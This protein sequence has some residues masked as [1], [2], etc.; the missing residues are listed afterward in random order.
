MWSTISPLCVWF[1][2]F[3]GANLFMNCFLKFHFFFL[4]LVVSHPRL[5]CTQCCLNLSFI[6]TKKFN[7]YLYLYPPYQIKT[8]P[9]ADKIL[10][11]FRT[12]IFSSESN[13]KNWLQNRSII[14]Y[15]I[16][17]NFF[18]NNPTSNL[19]QKNSKQKIM[20]VF[21][22]QFRYCRSCQACLR[23]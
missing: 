16:Y 10:F 9:N 6:F 21:T 12:I 22:N 7:F 13:R 23:P 5:S 1:G 4:F 15:R 20:T 19:T 2:L 17:P 11:F 8:N 18:L 3:S 14:Y